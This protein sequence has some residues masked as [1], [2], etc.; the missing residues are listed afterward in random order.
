[1]PMKRLIIG[2]IITLSLLSCHHLKGNAMADNSA[3]TPV[4]EKSIPVYKDSL[5]NVID[6]DT[7]YTEL[8]I[9]PEYPG[10]MTE[11]MKFISKNFHPT[12]EMYEE[13]QS[14]RVCAR[15]IV[16][17]DGILTNFE[18]YGKLPVTKVTH[19]FIDDVLKKMPAFKPAMKDG[20]PV[21]CYF[22]VPINW[23]PQ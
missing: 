13:N 15:F 5:G 11:M 1:M 6:T 7:V 18:P 10:G 23:R 21:R 9:M 20:K 14:S 3:I 12:E 2:A 17:K 4:E 19:H 16:E 8:E 22:I